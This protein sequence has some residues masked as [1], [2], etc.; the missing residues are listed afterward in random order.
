MNLC[1]E[2]SYRSMPTGGGSLLTTLFFYFNP[3]ILGSYWIGVR[4]NLRVQLFRP[5]ITPSAV[6]GWRVKASRHRA[7]GHLLGQSNMRVLTG[8]DVRAR[9]P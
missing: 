5:S 8:V 9:E 4:T 3:L 7:R 6:V 1:G 2:E